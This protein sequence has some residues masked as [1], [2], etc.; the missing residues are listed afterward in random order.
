MKNDN[1]YSRYALWKGI[2]FPS[3]EICGLKRNDGGWLME[4]SLT[5]KFRETGQTI[6]Y[7]IFS[8]CNFNSLS[9]YI[10]AVSPWN[11]KRVDLQLR[12]EI[13]S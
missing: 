9:A 5:A 2:M 4:C 11:K 3:M 7:Q 1:G 10:E 6:V 12:A 8:D 13:G